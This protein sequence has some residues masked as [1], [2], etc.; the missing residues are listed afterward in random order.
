VKGIFESVFAEYS[1]LERSVYSK[2]SML[3]ISH[4]IEDVVVHFNLE[5]DLFVSFQ[6]FQFFLYEKERYLKL[7]K[8]CRRVFIFA[9]G[10]DRN[11]IAEFCNTEF[12][13]ISAQSPLA[14]EW[15]VIVNHPKHSIVL[16]TTEQYDRQMPGDDDFRYFKGMLSFEPEVVKVAVKQAVLNLKMLSID[17]QPCQISELNL[18]EDETNLNRKIYLFINRLLNEVELKVAKL[19]NSNA[20][21]KEALQSNKL[22]SFEMVQRLCYAAE[23][24]DDDTHGHLS[25]ISE[26]SALLYSMVENQAVEIEN[27][28]FAAQMHDIGKIGIPDAILMKPGK[29]TPSEFEIIKSHPI[30]GSKILRDSSLPLIQMGYNIALN[31][32]EKWDGSGYPYGLK[33]KDIPLV[34][35]VVAVVDVFD[36]LASKRVYKEAF[37]IEY[38]LEILRKER[39]KHFDGELIDL[40]MD[41][42]K[43]F[44]KLRGE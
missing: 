3:E 35:R 9:Q 15:S 10:I 20:M 34:A 36:A 4:A 16:S 17:Y 42:I 19:M 43:S 40:F 21:L 30:I 13:E 8:C 5:A 23:F 22:L 14:D 7:E 39:N 24:R 37:P 38:C 2:P 27:M 41:N 26:F 6:Q 12:V 1:F 32:H 44:L 28:R 18:S 25:R 11:Q 33:G 31:H 29:L